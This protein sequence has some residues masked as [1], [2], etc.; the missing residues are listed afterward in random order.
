M[1]D[2]DAYLLYSFI[3]R[4]HR[5][6]ARER[7]LQPVNNPDIL[8]YSTPETG[9][10]LSEVESQIQV[11]ELLSY[12]DSTTRRMFTLRL[13]GYPASQTTFN[14]TRHSNSSTD[15]PE[16]AGSSEDQWRAA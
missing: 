1:R 16:T 2:I 15:A 9:R 4:L 12:M 8:S 10:P 5:V 13:E 14:G 3:R 11:Q 7:R 6:S